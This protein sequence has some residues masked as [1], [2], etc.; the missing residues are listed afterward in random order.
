[1]SLAHVR[2]NIPDEIDLSE[3]RVGFGAITLPASEKTSSLAT[4][5]V[6]MD[7]MSREST[8]MCGYLHLLLFYNK[9]GLARL[10]LIAVFRRKRL[11]S[12]SNEAVVLTSSS[13]CLINLNLLD[14]GIPYCESTFEKSPIDSTSTCLLSKAESFYTLLP[15]LG[16][17]IFANWAVSPFK[18]SRYLSICD[19]NFSAICSITGLPA[20][21][22]M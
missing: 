8:A 10:S 1:M 3:R 2:T 4:L 19:C 21:M 17:S 14:F 13:K 16:L 7:R 20:S 11:T 9:N 18:T 6:E 22:A 15:N 5:D 12:L